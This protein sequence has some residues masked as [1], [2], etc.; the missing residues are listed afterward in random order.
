MAEALLGGHDYIVLPLTGNQRVDPRLQRFRRSKSVPEMSGINDGHLLPPSEFLLHTHLPSF[1]R[2]AIFFI[3]CLAIGTVC[4]YFLRD[5][6]KGEKI[7]GI[8]DSVYFCIVTITTVGYGDLVPNSVSTKLLA[9]AFSFLG[10]ALVGVIVSKAADYLVEK[11]Q[12]MLIQ[13]L[14]MRQELGS[15]EISKGIET[16]SVRI[17]HLIDNVQ[18]KCFITTS[19]LVVL[20]IIGTVFLAAV[21]K[22]DIVDAF[23]CVCSTLTTLGYGDKSFSTKAGRI[24][25]IFWILISTLCL[26]KLLCYVVEIHTERRHK[27]FEWYLIKRSTNFD[28]ES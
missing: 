17:K 20:V 12:K 4:F 7:N 23:Y 6:I 27:A 24:F 2:V 19:L 5:Q 1:K 9:C 13:A 25:A 28:I 16:E 26:V 22:L 14:D 8:L 10:V 11:Q 15:T 3:F 21:E 18:Y